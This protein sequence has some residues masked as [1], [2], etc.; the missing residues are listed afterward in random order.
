VADD[1]LGS[2]VVGSLAVAVV[3]A[4]VL[5][6][7]ELPGRTGKV[8]VGSDTETGGGGTATGTLGTPRSA[9]AWGAASAASANPASV[10]AAAASA[11]AVRESPGEDG[12]SEFTSGP[13]WAERR[14][15]SPFR[16][17][18]AD[19]PGLT[20]ARGDRYKCTR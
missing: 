5:V 19:A 10:S 7:L 15:F 16:I 20:R 6:V 18:A 3:S 13:P 4:G 9:L 12:V 11:G 8:T 1:E 17:G 14:D 2:L